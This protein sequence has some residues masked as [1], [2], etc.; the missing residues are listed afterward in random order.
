MRRSL[1]GSAAAATLIALTLCLPGATALAG[2]SNPPGNNGTI[3]VNENGQTSNSNDPHVGCVF[4]LDLFG[5]DAGPQ[6][7]EVTFEVVPPT[8]RQVLFT[9]TVAFA[10]HGAGGS[11]DGFDGKRTYSLVGGLN[12]FAPGEQGWH[13]KL[14]THTTG[15]QGAD[16]KSKTFWVTGCEAPPP[17][18]DN[19]GEN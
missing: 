3:K 1:P 15:S 5:A 19:G 9:D 12:A 7:A 8:G 16:T 11:M 2:N 4:E 17:P 10:G 18:P 6:T 14:T 13:I